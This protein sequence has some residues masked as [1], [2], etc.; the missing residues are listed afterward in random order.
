[1]SVL[2]STY[3]LYLTSVFMDQ[4]CLVIGWLW[5]QTSTKRQAVPTSFS[6]SRSTPPSNVTTSS[7]PVILSI[8]IA[9]ILKPL[10]GHGSLETSYVLSEMFVS[11]GSNYKNYRLQ[12]QEAMQ[13]GRHEPMFRRNLLSRTYILKTESAGSWSFK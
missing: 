5:V 3:T 12:G 13:F 4:Y 7:Q 11:H 2:K 9:E 10:L 1:M 6:P 8:K